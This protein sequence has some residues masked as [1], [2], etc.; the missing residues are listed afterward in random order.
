MSMPMPTATDISA[1]WLFSS[2]SR[3]LHDVV[4]RGASFTRS[5]S[6]HD[7]FSLLNDTFNVKVERALQSN[8]LVVDTT[9]THKITLDPVH[10]TLM[11]DFNVG[12]YASPHPPAFANLVRESHVVDVP[13]WSF[14]EGSAM[15]YMSHDASDLLSIA[16]RL[17]LS[18]ICVRHQRFPEYKFDLRAMEQTNMRSNFKRRIAPPVIKPECDAL[19]DSD[20]DLPDHMRC[21]LSYEPFVD[22]VV[23]SDGFTYER[24]YIEEWFRQG[25]N[26]SPMTR[27]VF[28]NTLNALYPNKIAKML[29]EQYASKKRARSDESVGAVKK[30]AV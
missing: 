13:L 20:P 24:Y 23:A 29:V 5:R 14:E 19:L 1:T 22:P 16:K 8:S 4:G 9:S 12:D 18:S 3:I 21:P 15:K 28:P 6:D 27:Q 26:T 7:V 2:D 17:D 10:M 11:L 25:K 30:Q